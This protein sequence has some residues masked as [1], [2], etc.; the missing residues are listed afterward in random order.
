MPVVNK[1]WF[2][3]VRRTSSRQVAC[4]CISVAFKT[5]LSLFIIITLLTCELQER[6]TKVTQSNVKEAMRKKGKSQFYIS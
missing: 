6:K 5:F 4:F 1:I 3:V 2:C